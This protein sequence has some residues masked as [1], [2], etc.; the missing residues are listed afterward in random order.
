MMMMMIYI[1]LFGALSH[2]LNLCV[3]IVCCV[4]MAC[5]TFS[6]LMTGIG[7]VKHVCVCEHT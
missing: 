2:V 1:V 5:F 4:V 3:C 6:C 7:S